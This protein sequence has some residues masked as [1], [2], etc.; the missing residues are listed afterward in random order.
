M[1]VRC[2]DTSS[3]VTSQTVYYC[4]KLKSVHVLRCSLRRHWHVLSLNYTSTL[5]LHRWLRFGYVIVTSVIQSSFFDAILFLTRLS[6][7]E[8]TCA[9]CWYTCIKFCNSNAGFSTSIASERSQNSL[10]LGENGQVEAAST[11]NFFRRR[12]DVSLSSSS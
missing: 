5:A 2:L 7:S 10:Y 6:C 1:K 3:F 4:P 9:R 8:C 11:W 12:L